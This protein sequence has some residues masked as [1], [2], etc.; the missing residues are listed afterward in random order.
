MISLSLSLLSV[1][2]VVGDAGVEELDDQGAGAGQGHNDPQHDHHVEE[3][4]TDAEVKALF[5]NPDGGS[6]QGIVASSWSSLKR[7]AEGIQGYLKEIDMDAIFSHSGEVFFGRPSDPPKP[8]SPSPRDGG[9]APVDGGGGGEGFLSPVPKLI[10]KLLSPAKPEVEKPAY[11]YSAGSI[12]KLARLEENIYQA[13]RKY[14]Y[15]VQRRLDL[16]NRSVLNLY[17]KLGE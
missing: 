5:D 11:L 12:R 9:K 1:G 13:I 4:E 2:V 14:T 8:N 15:I 6:G 17:L 7:T 3:E 10:K 16:M